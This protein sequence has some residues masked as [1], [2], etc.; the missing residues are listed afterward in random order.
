MSYYN[1]QE[2]I[3]KHRK[4]S[5]DFYNTPMGRFT[6]YKRQA[7]RRGL[8]F[9]FTFEQFMNLWQKEC[10]YCGSEIKYIGIDRM[11]NNFG[12]I[13]TN[14]VSC[15]ELCNRMKLNFEKDE[16]IKHIRKII[17]ISENGGSR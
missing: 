10:Y 6:E 7:K 17:Q 4:R 12:Y 11:D 9:E 13:I 5:S 16:W 2:K 3:E 1:T 15:C 8:V 14:S